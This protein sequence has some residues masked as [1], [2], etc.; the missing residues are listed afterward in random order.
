LYNR[1]NI[2][3]LNKF[4]ELN[5]L[6]APAYAW[7][8]S[9]TGD[10]T[11]LTEGDLMFQHTFDS[12]SYAFSGKQFS[13]VY[14]WSFDYVGWRSGTETSAVAEVNNPYG[15]AYADTEP[16]IEFAIEA[17]NITATSVN[18]R[19]NT[20]EPADSQIYYGLTNQYGY[21]SQ[22][23]D[24]GE[25]R[26]TSHLVSALHLQPGTVYHFQ[27]RSHDAANNLAASHDYTFTT[28]K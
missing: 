19:W 3:N 6:V 4:T 28:K 7:Y 22:L 16:P 9:K 11:Y 8:W 20:Y 5:D 25:K 10:D 23:I 15:G 26:K 1:Y 27:V 2:P 17:G 18:I 21:S 13:Q 12:S 24:K 14:K